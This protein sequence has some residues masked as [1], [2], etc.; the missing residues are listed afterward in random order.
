MLPT[1][2]VEEELLVVDLTDGHPTPRF[3]DLSRAM[4][5][6]SGGNDEVEHEFKREQAEIASAPF[7]DLDE[8]RDDLAGRR[9]AL[10]AA[11]LTQ[12]LGVAALGSSPLPVRP[13]PTTNP[14]Y[15]VMDAEFGLLA[16]RQLTC[17]AHVHVAVGSR[18][19]GV[20]VLNRLRPWL[21][22]VAALNTNSPYWNGA[23][24]GYASYRSVVWSQW[25]TAGP[26]GAFDDLTSYDATIDAMLRT[27]TILDDA[28]VYFDARLSV[29]YP[30]VEVRVADVCRDVADSALLAALVRGLVLTAG[31]AARDG[32]VAPPIRTEV[33]RLAAWRAARSGMD[34]D[35]V[36]VI[37]ARPR[38]AAVL[39]DR[40]VDAIGPALRRAGDANLVSDGLARIVDRGT[41]A[42]RQRFVAGSSGDLRAV[43]LD[44]VHGTDPSRAAV[45]PVRDV[46]TLGGPAADLAP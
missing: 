16:A 27:E 45:T 5:A 19:E 46:A 41:G 3:D 36:D 40:L 34:G 20:A 10:A 43:V 6:R 26:F 29:R 18:A 30:T 44:A 15:Q 31:D 42:R 28:M 38:P 22:V 24:S 2:G 35:L 17:G 14:R 13:T 8:L 32:T 25:P 1:V 9:E 21:A 12:G 37:A 33:L 23:D 4:R 39:V 11:A 7:T